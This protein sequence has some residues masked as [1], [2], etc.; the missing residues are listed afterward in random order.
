M[1]KFFLKTLF[2]GKITKSN[3]DENRIVYISPNNH[4]NLSTLNVSRI[5]KNKNYHN[6]LIQ[7]LRL[8]DPS[9]EDI[10]MLQTEGV[11]G[12]PEINIRRK[13]KD[14]A[15]PISL[16]GD[17]MKKVIVLATYLVEAAGGV[18][19]IDEVETSLHYSLFNDVF[20]FLLLA[21]KKF[22]VQLFIATHN[23]EAIDSILN[24]DEE[25]LNNTC[26]IT[27]RNNNGN[28]SYRC[29]N[30]KDAKSYRRTISLEVR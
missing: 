25:R 3:K 19:L 18:L 13:G 5:L 27:L 28:L 2:Y 26:L 6:I 22:N 24:V 23:I 9:I 11:F 21:A 17:G 10:L 16:F 8:F 20:S 30:G 12:L 29:L 15:E 7:L 4:Y 14:D 1:H